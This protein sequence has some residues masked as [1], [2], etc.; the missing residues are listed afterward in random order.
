MPSR[1]SA[2][3]LRTWIEKARAIGELKDVHGADL[4]FELGAITDLNAKQ[5][6]P[7]LLF[8]GFAGF[9]EK[10][11]VLTGSMLNAST[12]GLTIG[13]E[14]RLGTMALTN[15]VSDLLRELERTAADYPVEYVDDG[16]VMENRAA[17]DAVDLGIFPTPT[18]HE[19][20][21]GAFIGTGCLQVH[22]DPD[23]G[24]VNAAAYRVQRHDRNTVG[25]FIAQG[26]HGAIIR[27]KYWD[28]DEPC[29]V[30]IVFGSHPLFLVIG[31][32]EVPAG[33]D[34]FTWIG[35]IAGQRVPVIRGPVTGLPIP[36]DAEVAIE[37]FVAKGDRQDEGPFGEFTGYY[38]GGRKPE[39]R[40]HAQA[41]YYRNDPI[42]LGAPPSRPVHDYS[43]SASVLRSALVKESLRRAGVPAV[44]GVWMAEAGG[45]RMWVVTSIQQQYAGHA[46]QAASVAV[47]C[48]A[49]GMLNRYSIV[50][51]EDID[52]SNHEDVVWALSTRSDPATDI[53]VIRQCWS[54][55][56]DPMLSAASKAAL[57]M[58]NSRAIINA[59]RPWDRLQA[60]DF[61][62]VAEASPALVEATKKKWASLFRVGPNTRSGRA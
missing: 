58:W 44:R 61:P 50:V 7:A 12:L 49:G 60:G 15:R 53:D 42:L 33:V 25:N 45:S 38:A 27:R 17:G 24:W 41:L 52:P 5:R 48:Q 30:A 34:E 2:F 59:C 3:D 20:D 21:G 8:G 32:L 55:P 57:Q 31:G 11:R 43:F 19:L 23:S 56:L 62:P 6:G 47:Q 46:A 54:N 51:D 16:P 18:W 40:I 37:G 22:R 1:A 4:R 39:A 26:H 13:I 28:R 10:H 36:A 35:A 14:E 9:P 29:P